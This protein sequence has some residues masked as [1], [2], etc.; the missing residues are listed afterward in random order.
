MSEPPGTSCNP[1][2]LGG[3]GCRK[4]RKRN[5]GFR[6]PWHRED[7]GVLELLVGAS[8]GAQPRSCHS[9]CLTD[10]AIPWP[11]GLETEPISS[12]SGWEVEVGLTS[13]SVLS[14]P[15]PEAGRGGGHRCSIR[16]SALLPRPLSRGEGSGAGTKKPGQPPPPTHAHPE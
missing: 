10:P 14:G 16:T 2:P 11:W 5:P 6:L 15:F 4:P 7:G 3:A 8:F 13:G 12:G 9:A 1:S